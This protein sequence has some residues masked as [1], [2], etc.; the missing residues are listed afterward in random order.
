MASHSLSRL[1]TI[2]KQA[3]A[4]TSAPARLFKQPG[5]VSAE[6]VRQQMRYVLASCG[7][8]RA[9][10]IRH[11]LSFIVEEAL[12]G[13]ADQICEYAIGT[14]V[15]GRSESFEPGLDPIVR[16]DARRLRQKLFEYYHSVAARVPNR[17]LIEVPKGG[18]V[19]V[20]S[21]SPTNARKNSFEGYRL[22][23]TLSRVSD[24]SEISSQCWDFQGAGDRITIEVRSGETVPSAFQI[25]SLAPPPARLVAAAERPTL[26]S[27][28][29][30]RKWRK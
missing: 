19:P 27:S 3:G 21:F 8:T 26:R 2:P 28:D 5:C 18:Y 15:Y 16:N 29:P 17:V 30:V 20:F 4:L 23:V 10:R 6:A 7:F 12:A 24:G 1:L 14:V 25:H 9:S 22:N 11:F 13:R